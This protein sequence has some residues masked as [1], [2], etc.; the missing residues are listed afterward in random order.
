MMLYIRM[1]VKHRQNFKSHSLLLEN[2]IYKNGNASHHN[3]SI[4]KLRVVLCNTRKYK[5]LK[6]VK[7]VLVN[8]EM[9]GTV[10]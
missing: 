7:N 10:L 5:A 6:I 1:H 9:T 2:K 3:V 8:T 4:T